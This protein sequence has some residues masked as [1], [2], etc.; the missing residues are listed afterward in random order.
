[1]ARGLVAALAGVQSVIDVLAARGQ[2]VRLVPSWRSGQFSVE[3]AGEVLLPG[4]DA[5]LAPTTFDA[6]LATEATRG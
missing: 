5:R 4:P 3:M 2:S 6:W 1:M